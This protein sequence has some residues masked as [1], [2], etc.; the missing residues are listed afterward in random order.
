[1]SYAELMRE[2]ISVK[3]YACLISQMAL[4]NKQII[5][6]MRYINNRNAMFIIIFENASG[7]ITSKKITLPKEYAVFFTSYLAQDFPDVEIEA[8]PIF[9]KKGGVSYVA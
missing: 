5:K 2:D 8:K 6:V 4:Y 9:E 1:M 3:Q 7:T